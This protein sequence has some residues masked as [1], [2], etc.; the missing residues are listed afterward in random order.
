[1]AYQAPA[2]NNKAMKRVIRMVGAGVVS[3]G[4]VGVFALPAY[5]TPETEELR[6]YSPVQELTT[7]NSDGDIALSGPSAELVPVETPAPA[8]QEEEG[9]AAAAAAQLAAFSGADLPAGAGAS[10]LVN[11]ALAQ[12]GWGQDCTAMVENAMRAIGYPV[13]DVGVTGFDGYGSIVTSGGYA[14]GDILVWPGQPHVAIYIGNGQ[15]VHGGFNGTTLVAS[16]RS[17]GAEPAYVVRI[18]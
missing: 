10:G 13:G 6:F 8:P 11:A 15:A 9:D 7:A 5:A 14:P 16:Y 4:M 1:V 12:L 3:V 2:A 17:M 18:G